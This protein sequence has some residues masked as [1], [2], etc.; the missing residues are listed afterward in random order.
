[1]LR[2]RNDARIL[3]GAEEV[4]AALGKIIEPLL[5]EIEQSVGDGLLASA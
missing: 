4:F 1:L 5:K 3:F 2:R